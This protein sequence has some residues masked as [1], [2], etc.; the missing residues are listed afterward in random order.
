MMISIQI[1]SMALQLNENV[2]VNKDQYD[3]MLK[4][5]CNTEMTINSSQLT[6]NKGEVIIIFIF[7]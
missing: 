4:K 1:M 5:F 7:N 3:K 6:E 2:I